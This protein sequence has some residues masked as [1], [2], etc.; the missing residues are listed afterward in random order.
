[1]THFLSGGFR[2]QRR[3]SPSQ[4]GKVTSQRAQYNQGNQPFPTPPA[5]PGS[6]HLPMFWPITECLWQTKVNIQCSQHL[7]H[8]MEVRMIFRWTTTLSTGESV[9][10][11][12]L[13]QAELGIRLKDE[14]PRKFICTRP[15]LS[16]IPGKTVL[17]T[18]RLLSSDMSGILCDSSNLVKDCQKAALVESPLKLRYY[19]NSRKK[20]L[21]ERTWNS[22][23][24]SKTETNLSLWLIYSKHFLLRCQVI[25]SLN[26]MAM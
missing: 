5:P 2:L 3:L 13:R 8:S 22:K 15:E 23:N 9:E 16:T 10:R 17:P 11:T 12:H 1:M 6:P 14:A 21:N 24:K 7:E 19:L 4:S 18:M 26:Y 25:L 20:W